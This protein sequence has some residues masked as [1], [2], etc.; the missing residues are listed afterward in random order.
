MGLPKSRTY[1]II[2][3]CCFS[4]IS[5]AQ[6]QINDQSLFWLGSVNDF[7]FNKHWG[8]NADFHFRTFDFLSHPYNYIV[9]ARGDYYFNETLTAG[10]GYGHMWSAALTAPRGPFSN[11]DRITEQVQVT[12]KKNKIAFS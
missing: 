1:L 5:N 7:R 6:K 4:S 9:R 8:V 3:C 11:E 10:M 2:L 12:S